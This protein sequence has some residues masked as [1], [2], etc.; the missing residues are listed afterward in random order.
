MYFNYAVRNEDLRAISRRISAVY[1]DKVDKVASGVYAVWVAWRQNFRIIG[2][3][4]AQCT[5]TV[6]AFRVY[7]AL[8]SMKR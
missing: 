3:H 6:L 7:N 5:H 2:L 8:I 4:G 1:G